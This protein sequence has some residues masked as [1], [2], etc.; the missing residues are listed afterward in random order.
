VP[1][2]VC[3]KR[4]AHTPTSNSSPQGEEQRALLSTFVIPGPRSGARNL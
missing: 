2:R 4:D 3:D 1:A